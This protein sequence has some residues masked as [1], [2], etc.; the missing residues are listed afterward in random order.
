MRVDLETQTR[1]KAFDALLAEYGAEYDETENLIHTKYLIEEDIPHAAIG[2]AALLLRIFDFLLLT[3]DHVASTFKED[4]TKG[5]KASI[6]NRATVKENDPVNDKLMEVVPDLVVTA[7]GRDPVAVF[8]SQSP[9]RVHEAIFLQMAAFYEAKQ[10]LSVVALLETEG[11]LTRDMHRRAR[12]RLAAVTSWEGDQDAAI[13]RI[14]REVLGPH[15]LV[16]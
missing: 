3:Q 10:P 9:M 16:H 15:A 2:F 11:T 4:A 5:I 12:N 13:Q 14:E 8:L 1:R 7:P 6:G